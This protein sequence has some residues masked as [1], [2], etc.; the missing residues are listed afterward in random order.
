MQSI[1]A[2]GHNFTTKSRF[3]SFVLDL[4][5]GFVYG[6]IW[7]ES[8]LTWWTVKCYH[9]EK[10][11]MIFMVHDS[12]TTN[13]TAARSRW[14]SCQTL[15]SKR[16]WRCHALS[17]AWLNWGLTLHSCCLE[18]C[19]LTG[20]VWKQLVVL[21]GDHRAHKSYMGRNLWNKLQYQY[22]HDYIFNEKIQ[23]EVVFAS[24]SC[25]KRVVYCDWY[26]LQKPSIG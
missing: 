3:L 22:I 26:V 21:Q 4:G 8:S 10:T 18:V 12:A 2:S 14:K 20:D 16:R 25:L 11:N 6:T 7:L 19:L 1:K 5:M 9:W 17:R 13:A 15:R 23:C 24:R